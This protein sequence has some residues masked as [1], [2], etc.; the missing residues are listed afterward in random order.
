MLLERRFE[1]SYRVPKVVRIALPVVSLALVVVLLGFVP[2]ATHFT[3]QPQGA[4]PEPARVA[5]INLGLFAPLICG[6]IFIASLFQKDRSK[7]ALPCAAATI[8]AFCLGWRCYPYWVAGVYQMDLGAVPAQD[9]D[10][11]M[12]K[13]M[14][15]LSEIWR[16]G[17][18][19]GSLAMLLVIPGSLPF[20]AKL[21]RRG[22]RS[23]AAMTAAC[24]LITV[25]F[26]FA[27]QTHYLGW[28]L[29]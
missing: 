8:A 15:S 29:D 3:P 21:F 2:F 11:K 18:L 16:L 12:L 7:S 1:T 6:A 5:M 17:V 27:W 20:I 19:L 26:M 14:M 13:P 23:S 24:M 28:L 22:E 25:V 4:A 10:P 9:M